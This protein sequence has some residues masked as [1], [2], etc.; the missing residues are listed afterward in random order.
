M[1]KILI[2]LLILSWIP[3][4]WAEEI[5]LSIGEQRT[6]LF[7][8]LKKVENK[9]KKLTRV[10]VYPQRDEVVIQA[11]SKGNST[12][13]IRDDLGER[14]I[15]VIVYSKL[16]LD[17]ER[18]I[19]ELTSH[20]E[21]IEVRQIGHQVILS[22]PVLTP[23][24]YRIVQKIEKQYDKVTNLTRPLPSSQIIPLDKMIQIELKMIETNTRKLRK[25]GLELPDSIKTHFS[26]NTQHQEGLHTTTFNTST[27]F[28]LIFHALE[29]K[30]L[31]KILANPKL[32]CKNGGEA[33]FLAGGEIPIRLAHERSLSVQWKP[34]GIML[35]IQPTAD[36]RDHIFATIKVEISTLNPSQ[37]I[38][39]V[40]G[41]LT[42]K[43]Q[44]SINV[45]NNETIILSGLVHQ[46]NGEDI[47]KVPVIS[48]LPI[49]GTLF[50]SKEFQN[51]NSELIIFVTPTIRQTD[52]EKEPDAYLAHDAF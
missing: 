37:M 17:L 29:K 28:D 38:E 9:N 39:G 11:I 43:L 40:P 14:S 7:P 42:R 12:L 2:I 51:S 26:I 19:K 3:S 5:R 6:L 20:I 8:G 23:E 16:A 48:A 44:T 36:S 27:Q 30:G 31:A 33:H 32:I 45:R 10:R 46:E 4:L 1:R 35:H 50:Q 18:E 52:P 25:I 21:G 41:I 34:Y 15:A 22:G 49:L 13:L 24:D 47:R